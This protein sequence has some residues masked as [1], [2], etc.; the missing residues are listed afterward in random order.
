MGA[1]AATT[2]RHIGRH[3]GPGATTRIALA[4]GVWTR[5]AARAAFAAALTSNTMISPVITNDPLDPLAGA[6]RLASK[7]ACE[8]CSRE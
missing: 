7:S 8:Q 6:V 2:A 1:L 5:D 3:F 4:G